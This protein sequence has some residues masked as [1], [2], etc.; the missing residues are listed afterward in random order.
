MKITIKGV[1]LFCGCGG[2]SRGFE[3]AGISIV[4]AYDFWPN[5]IDCYQ[6]NF[7]HSAKIADISDIK[8]MSEQILTLA[9]DIIIGGPPCQDFSSAGNRKEGARANLTDCFARIIA[10]IRPKWFV[11]ENVGRA[12]KSQAYRQARE[13]FSES[14]YGLTEK[15][16][17]ACAFGVPQNRRRF[18]SIGLL[19]AQDGFLLDN[20]GL[21]ESDHRVTVRQYFESVGHKVEMGHYY[22]HP[23]NYTRRGVFSVDELAPTMRGMNRPVPGGYSGHHGDTHNV[24]EV[25]PMTSHERA[26]IQTF[27]PDFKI[28]GSKTTVEQM[29]GNAVPVKLAKAVADAVLTYERT[30]RVNKNRERRTANGAIAETRNSTFIADSSRQII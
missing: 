12:Q 21:L 2:L 23:R 28:F 13:I 25:R 19:G 20:I 6:K 5:A 3:N 22:R 4:E 8:A 26:L 1:D 16:L 15:L 17:N 30:S 29:I 9:P 18:F 27:P 7:S 24:Q 10:T 11:M 14:G